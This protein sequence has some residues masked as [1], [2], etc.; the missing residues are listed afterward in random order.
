MEYIGVVT[1]ADR[2]F[3][4]L[5]ISCS[6][7]TTSS[8]LRHA[9]KKEFLVSKIIKVEN[10]NK[11]FTITTNEK[12]LITNLTIVFKKLKNEF[13]GTVDITIT[14]TNSNELVCEVT[15]QFDNKHECGYKIV[16]NPISAEKWYHIL[17]SKMKNIFKQYFVYYF[18]SFFFY[19]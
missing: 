14:E 18:F 9:L 8:I 7:T 19:D 1:N 16:V 17:I 4:T 13:I 5:E 11:N 15:C 6:N 2:K 10:N 3:Y 12:Y